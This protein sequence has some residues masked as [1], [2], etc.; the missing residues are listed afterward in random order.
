MNSIGIV[1]WSIWA[2]IFI[3]LLGAFAIS[4]LVGAIAYLLAK[5]RARRQLE[6][7][8][9]N[10]R[11]EQLH[12]ELRSI[13]AQTAT[14]TIELVG[15]GPFEL[16]L[17]T[18]LDWLVPDEKDGLIG[19]F[20]SV[21]GKRIYASISYRAIAQLINDCR[22]APLRK[23]TLSSATPVELTKPADAYFLSGLIRFEGHL[24][25]RGNIR[26]LVFS[27]QGG[28]A[29]LLPLSMETY[30]QLLL[31]SKAALVLHENGKRLH[32]NLPGHGIRSAIPY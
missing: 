8:K 30:E 2:H 18:T 23:P 10:S 6:I 12:G 22:A 24:Q 13:L 19:G 25:R 1:L 5:V 26:V 16:P 31:Q 32:E 20:Q 17:M 27:C 7:Q 29:I 14:L 15:P 21:E 3:P 4:I 9:L 28:R 11:I